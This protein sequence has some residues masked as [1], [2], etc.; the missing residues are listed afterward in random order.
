MF[1][2]GT[3]TRPGSLGKPKRGVGRLALETGA[4]VVPV[5]VDRHRGRPPGLADPSAQGPHPR[6]APAALPQG[7]GR[8]AGAG[9]R[10]HRPDLAVRDA[11]VGVARRPA[12]DSP[13]RDHRRRHVGHQPGRAARA[14]GIRGRPWLPHARAGRR[15]RRSREQRRATCRASS[16][17]SSVHVIARRRARARR[18]RPHL[19]GGAG[20][21]AARG[22]GRPRRADPAA[23][24]R[25]GAVQGARAAARH[26]ALGVRLRALRARAVAVLGGPAAR[27]RRARARRLGR[28]RVARPR[29]R[30]AS[31][32]TRCAPPASR[33][34]S[35]AT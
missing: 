6:R 22:A 27:R 7:R 20:P 31:S 25:A 14:R 21:G 2:E 30:A 23:G 4:P 33:S 28:A 13:R 34:P 1:P 24:R 10:G 32:P 3:R 15:A 9:R 35:R 18:P 17:P 12:P 11:A 29:L 8:L 26:A 5:A 19:P 16:C